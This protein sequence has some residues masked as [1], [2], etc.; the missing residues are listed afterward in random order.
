MGEHEDEGLM[1]YFQVAGTEGA[2]YS[3]SES[4]DTKC[5]RGA[6]ADRGNST[7]TVDETCIGAGSTPPTQPAGFPWLLLVGGIALVVLLGGVA[8]YFFFLRKPGQQNE[9]S[10]TTEMTQAQA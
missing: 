4:L 6:F 7:H 3:C 8:V 10:E 1:G 2:K 5:Y 9:E